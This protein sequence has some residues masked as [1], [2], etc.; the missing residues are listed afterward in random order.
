MNVNDNKYHQDDI[1]TKE[2]FKVDIREYNKRCTEAER[3]VAD[4]SVSTLVY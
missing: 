3:R 2:P 4:L 1:S